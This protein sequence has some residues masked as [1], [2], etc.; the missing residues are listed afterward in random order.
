MMMTTRDEE[1]IRRA[2]R[3]AVQFTREHDTDHTCSYL[4]D[5]LPYLRDDAKKVASDEATRT[6]A[7]F[8]GA[9]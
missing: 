3:F 9:D 5:L 8:I 7:D 1:R 6:L 2:I 4:F